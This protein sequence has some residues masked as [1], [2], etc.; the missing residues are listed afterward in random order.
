MKG[1]AYI[2]K[3]LTEQEELGFYKKLSSKIIKD[4]EDDPIDKSLTLR[5]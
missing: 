5:V 2:I 3:E 4:L 1:S